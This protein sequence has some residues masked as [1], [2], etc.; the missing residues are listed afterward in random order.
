[1]NSFADI[2]WIGAGFTGQFFFTVRFI[3]QW[4]AKEK[5]KKS[6]VPEM[7]WYFSLLG[8]FVLLAYSIHKKDPVFIAGQSFGSVIYLRNLY[9]IF[10]EKRLEDE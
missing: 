8:S 6:V 9:Y 3:V 10:K 4:L 7:F 1:M 5:K 2:F